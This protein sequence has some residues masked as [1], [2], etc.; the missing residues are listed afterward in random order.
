[1]FAD[2]FWQYEFRKF[3]S[4]TTGQTSNIVE[5]FHIFELE[6]PIQEMGNTFAR[7]NFDSAFFW[8]ESDRYIIE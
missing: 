6:L 1:M 8:W 4:A 5:I 7:K 3:F 2:T